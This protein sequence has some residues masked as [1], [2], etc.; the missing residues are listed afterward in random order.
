MSLCRSCDARIRWEHTVTGKLIPLDAEARPD[1]NIRVGLVG[2]LE[3]AIL[4][5]DPAE[6]AAAQVAGPVYVSHFATC[7]NASSHRK[8]R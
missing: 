6:R 4:L 1:G 3:V 5:A 2:G 7:P 8:P